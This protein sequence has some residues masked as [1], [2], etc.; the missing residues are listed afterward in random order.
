M[1][2][3][4]TNVIVEILEKR[5]IKGEQLYSALIESGETISTTA[6]NLHEVMYGLRKY[7]QDFNL[8]Q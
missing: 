5:S 4:D 3:L 6:I 8:I 7:S 2:M 1:I